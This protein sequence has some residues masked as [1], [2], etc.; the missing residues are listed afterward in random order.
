MTDRNRRST[1]AAI[2]LPLLLVTM[3]GLARANIIFVN[4][5][6]G[7]SDAAPLCTLPDAIAAANSTFA[8]NG[9]SAGSG[10]DQIV[11][12][13][14][15]TIFVDADKLPLNISDES[16]VISTFG[17]GPVV[18]DGGLT[19]VVPAGGIINVEAG[20]KSLA[21]NGLTF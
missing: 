2:A 1:L 10:D 15:G 21:L 7:G 3:S 14:T 20:S 17:D 8:V 19:E 9:C 11:I 18:I 12:G 6:D 4:T 16:L 13:L 5:L